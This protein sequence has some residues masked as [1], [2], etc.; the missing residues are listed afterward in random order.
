MDLW[1]WR[2]DWW[3]PLNKARL[4]LFKPVFFSH[5]YSCPNVACLD[6]SAH[7]GSKHLEGNASNEIALVGWAP[8]R[9][10]FFLMQLSD[11]QCTNTGSDGEGK[12]I[13]Q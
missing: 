11:G 8:G 13:R 2:L 3:A 6:E 10:R 4:I 1:W 9:S 12:V 7:K 5:L